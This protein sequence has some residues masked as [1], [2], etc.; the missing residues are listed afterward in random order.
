MAQISIQE[1]T[2]KNMYK[3]IALKLA[4]DQVDRIAPNVYS[5]AESKVDPQFTPYAIHLD[6]EV[7]GFV[8]TECDREEIEERKYWIPRFMIDVS[9]QRKGYGKEAMQQV[10]DMLKKNDDCQYIGLSTEPDNNTA[11]RFYESLGFVNTGELLE[12]SEVILLLKV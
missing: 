3:C 1:L 10:I 9:Y 8:M 12:E 2:A 4:D 11:L 6:E 5:I 7:I